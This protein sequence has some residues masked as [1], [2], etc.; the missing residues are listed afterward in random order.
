[1]SIA[2]WPFYD[3]EEVEAVSK[4]LISGKVNKWTGNLCHEFENK[5]SYFCNAKYSISVANGTLA[6]YAAYLALGLKEGDEIIT[7]PR[8]FI[9]TASTAL[10]FG[11]K[12]VFADVDLDS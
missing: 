10:M 11:A 3:S 4:V 5:F 9:A 6:L 7:T 2:P 1:M 8:T 12:P